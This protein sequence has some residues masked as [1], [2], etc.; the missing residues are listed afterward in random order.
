MQSLS[1]LDG[2]YASQV[3]ELTHYFSEKAYHQYRIKIEVEYFITLVKFL[4]KET[5]ID[6]QKL[7]DIYKN[8]NIDGFTEIKKIESVINH[9]VK[10]VEYYVKSKIGYDKLV[11]YVHFG[12]TSHDINNCAIG[13][14][15][16]DSMTSVI[17]PSLLA[18]KNNL[19]NLAAK[20]NKQP[21][22]SRTHG[23]SATP[24]ILGKE[25]MV[26]V[27]RID[28]QLDLL[29]NIPYKVKFGGCIGN[30]NAHVFAYPEK[31][32]LSFADSFIHNFGLIRSLYTTQLNHYDN[33]SALFDNIKRINN[34]LINLNRDIWQYIS[35]G[36]FN[37]KVISTEVGSSTMPHKVNPINFENS[38]GNLMFANSI[39]SFLSNKLPISRLQRDLTDSTT[40]RNIGVGL[41]Y[42]LLGYKSL[43]KGLNKIQI[44]S[45]A[46]N[47]DLENNP[48]VIIEGL[49]TQLKKDG[50]PKPYEMFKKLFRNQ[51]HNLKEIYDF[52]D[53]LQ[54]SNESKQ[55]MKELTPSNYIGTFPIISITEKKEI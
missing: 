8:F 23:Q 2:R 20:Y 29:K 41:G 53:T 15:V 12:L 4:F 42:S 22:L 21:M 30:F 33:L 13:L 24:T 49:Q 47:D 46:I 11:E 37:Q 51:N 50:Y 6:N 45:S 26:F 19:F 34:I 40:V 55:K 7:R 36:Y 54:I 43:L 39:L 52:V 10:S 27:E 14:S 48:V 9:D 17:I 1:P 38:E 25:I 35:L 16:K 5:Q 44:N 28:D 31:D 32:W 18:I 3:E